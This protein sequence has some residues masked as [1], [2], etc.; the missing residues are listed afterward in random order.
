MFPR[1]AWP[2][3]LA[4][5]SGCSGEASSRLL[6][7]VPSADIVSPA[8]GVAD[9]GFDPAVVVIAS[10]SPSPSPSCAGALVA[11]DVVLTALH[12]VMLTAEPIDCALHRDA[13]IGAASPA[14]RAPASLRVLVGEDESSAVER[15]RGRGIVVPD[16]ATVCRA[17]IALLLL[18][19]GI[20]GIAPLVV[21]ATGVAQG[22]HVRTVGFAAG[23]AGPKLLRD[24]VP[25]VGVEAG[26]MELAE[27]VSGNGGG[28]ALDETTAEIVGVASRDATRDVAIGAD[29]YTRMDAFLPFVASAVAQS[30]SAPGIGADVAKVEKGPADM[31]AGCAAGADCAAGVCVSVPSPPAR[32]CSRACGAVDRCPARFR[33]V[34]SAQGAEVCVKT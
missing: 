22:D 32:Y 12:C 11:P 26:A 10:P 6:G 5:L 25:I 18:D 33:C 27:L 28:P 15:A 4:L 24:H 16:G 8:T 34:R 9:R 14:L 3:F 7:N 19:Q 13:A 2:P 17:D 30:R 31:G 1:A 23:G 20:D 29:V 21:R